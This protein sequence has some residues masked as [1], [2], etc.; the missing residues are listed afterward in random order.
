MYILDT[1]MVTSSLQKQYNTEHELTKIGQ[2]EV[3]LDKAGKN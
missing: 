1:F 2:T 3:N